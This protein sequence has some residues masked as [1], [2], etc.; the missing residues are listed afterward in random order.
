MLLKEKVA[1]INGVGDR[2]GKATA[3]LFAREG[4]TVV[5]ISRKSDLIKI[6]AEDIM[7]HGGKADYLVMD[8]TNQKEVEVGMEK[9]FKNYG[10]INILFN[11]AGGFYSKKQKLEEME[12]KFWNEVIKNNLKSVF[13]MSKTAIKYMKDRESNSIIN[14]SAAAKTLLDGNS[15]YATAKGGLISLTKNLA[16]EVRNDNIRVNCIRPGVI[17]NDYNQQN[18]DN[19]K[20]NVKRKGNSEDVANAALFFASDNSS[21]ITGQTLVVD[22]GE[23]LYLE[24]E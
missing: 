18:L 3:Y 22:G 5:L 20:K 24:I 19:P 9:I 21:W 16:R 1:V 11:N 8:T 4:A 7:K 6:I 15:A 10:K 14:I 17:R 2:F 12:E 13:F 23:E